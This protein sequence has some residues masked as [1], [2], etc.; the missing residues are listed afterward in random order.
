LLL[1]GIL[2]LRLLLCQLSASMID[3]QRMVGRLGSTRHTVL[4]HTAAGERVGRHLTQLPVA[5]S[6]HALGRHNALLQ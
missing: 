1:G 6:S 4:P 3:G 2:L 5:G